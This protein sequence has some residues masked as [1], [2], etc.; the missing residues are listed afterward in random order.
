VRSELKVS[1]RRICRV[2]GQHRAAPQRREGAG[3]WWAQLGR[4]HDPQPCRA[5]NGHPAQRPLCGQADLEPAAFHQGPLERQ[6]SGAPE[7]GSASIIED[8]PDLRIIEEELWQ[9]VADRLG[10]IAAS[11]R[12]GDNATREQANFRKRDDPAK[13][14]R[15]SVRKWRARKDSNL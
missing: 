4:H 15:I 8:V 14:V 12:I 9:Q 11:P 3:T 1:E 2:V 7:P 5:R 10:D 6:A 13:A